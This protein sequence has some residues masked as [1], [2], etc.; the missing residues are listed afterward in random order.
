ML[1]LLSGTGGRMGVI[2][3]IRYYVA[4]STG[5]AATRS[6][7]MRLTPELRPSTGNNIFV[8]ALPDQ[9]R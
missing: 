5:T 1:K 2:Y 7:M 8:F 3:R 9:A 4:A 6:G